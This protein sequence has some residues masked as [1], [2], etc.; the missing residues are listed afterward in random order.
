LSSVVYSTYIG[1]SDDDQAYAIALDAA[2]NA[3]VTGLTRSSDL[4]TTAGA[5]QTALAGTQD[6]FVVK[7]NA[8]GSELVYATY[9]GGSGSADVGHGIAVDALSNAYVTKVATSNDFPLTSG[10]ADSGYSSDEAFVT[11]LSATGAISYST[12]IGESSSDIGTRL[13]WTAPE[14]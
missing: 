14:A 2:G 11:K 13:R 3:Y 4:P 6:A 9:L 7:L 5:A 1:G 8:A 12:F 10:V